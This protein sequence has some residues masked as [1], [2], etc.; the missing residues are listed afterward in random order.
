MESIETPGHLQSMSFNQK[1]S[2]L[3]P[4]NYF[5]FYKMTCSF[6]AAGGTKDGWTGVGPWLR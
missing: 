3:I 4:E 6:K 2:M 5:N 1:R